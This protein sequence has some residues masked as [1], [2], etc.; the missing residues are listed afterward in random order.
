MERASQTIGSL[1]SKLAN[2]LEATASTPTPSPRDSETTGL[3]SRALTAA[4]STGR[5]LGAIGAVGPL[6][7]ALQGADAW[8]SDKALLASLPPQIARSLASR[9]SEDFDVIGYDLKPGCALAE[10]RAALAIVEAACEPAPVKIVIQELARL[11]SVTQSREREGTDLEAH[12]VGMAEG[13]S[14]FPADVIRDG[15]RSYAKCEKWRPSLS[16]IREYCWHRNRV[17]HSL[18][19]TLRSAA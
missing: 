12:Y 5:Q 11:N 18:R 1:T 14:D 4:N 15:C 6:L 10:I 7:T 16:E 19:D 9:V 17:R 2:S 3:P 8:R 13:L